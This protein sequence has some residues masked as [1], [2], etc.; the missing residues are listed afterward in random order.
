MTSSFSFRSDDGQNVWRK[1]LIKLALEFRVVVSIFFPPENFCFSN[2][3]S[4]DD[5]KALQDNVAIVP[6]QKALMAPDRSR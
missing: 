6:S 3:E 4:E 1:N 2:D 5:E